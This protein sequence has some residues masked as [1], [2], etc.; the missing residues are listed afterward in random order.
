M[1][2][3]LTRIP[4]TVGISLSLFCLF[5][6][7]CLWIGLSLSRHQFL[8]GVR[9]VIGTNQP[10]LR[11]EQKLPVK[12]RKRGEAPISRVGKRVPEFGIERAPSR[13]GA[14]AVDHQATPAASQ[15]GPCACRASLQCSSAWMFSLTKAPFFTSSSQGDKEVPQRYGK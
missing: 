9:F 14:R 4:K 6:F 7:V 8:Q 11:I 5:L 10:M 3:N 2:P 13:E 12:S 15:L 1:A